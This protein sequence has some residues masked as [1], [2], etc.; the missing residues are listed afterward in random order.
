MHSRTIFFLI[1]I[2][3]IS[4]CSSKRIAE[5]R[6]ENDSLRKLLEVEPVYFSSLPG[7]NRALDSIDINRGLQATRTGGDIGFSRIPSRLRDINLYV[8]QSEK[9]IVNMEWQ[10]RRSANFVSGSEMVVEALRSE[11]NIR[12]G[13]VKE[14][15]AVIEEY[16]LENRTLYITVGNARSSLSE[17][18]QEV[19]LLTAKL[20][21]LNDHL[22]MA[23]AAAL[24]AK[25]KA[26]EESARRSTIPD[27]DLCNEAL[28]LYG[29]AWSL[30]KKEAK[31]DA[32]ALKK[33]MQGTSLH[34]MIPMP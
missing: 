11:L 7:F 9:K 10:L 27:N 16:V 14:L 20:E 21:S 19:E 2:S 8:R 33:F 30:G 5:R 23:E 25:A 29:K 1:S 31:S 26:V 3:L 4:A 6:I 22:R 28:E 18:Q 34:A 17:M 15:K 13:E 12:A 24:Y 32:E